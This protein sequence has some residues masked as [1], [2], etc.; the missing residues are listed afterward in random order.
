RRLCGV[1]FSERAVRLAQALNPELDYRA[2]DVVTDVIGEKFEVATLIEV[3][4]HIVPAQLPAFIEAAANTITDNGKLV[5]TVPHSN[6]PLIDKHYQH[7]TGHQLRQLLAPH[8][9]DI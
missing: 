6:K 8:F 7:F 1:D 9:D 2:L 4:E 3:I 5:L